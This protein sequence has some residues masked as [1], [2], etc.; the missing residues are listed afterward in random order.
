[1]GTGFTNLVWTISAII[2]SIVL[3][4]SF[5]IIYQL[6]KKLETTGIFCNERLMF[7]HYGSFVSATIFGLLGNTCE[8]LG[9]EYSDDEN[10]AL[11][12]EIASKF[13]YTCNSPPWAVVQVLI[14]LA[15][16]K[17]G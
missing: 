7:V 1:M 5:R 15:F 2:L 12:F 16:I 3:G 14:M 11:R 8:I 4:F 13:F 17:Y 10:M 9:N 6:S